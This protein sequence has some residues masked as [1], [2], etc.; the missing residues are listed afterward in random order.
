MHD[1]APLRYLVEHTVQP[2]ETLCSIAMRYYG[3]E[4]RW[5]D[6]YKNTTN[7]RKSFNQKEFDPNRIP[8]GMVLMVPYPTQGVD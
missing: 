7:H 8:V 1:K 2:G 6:I 3:D 5:Q 4:S